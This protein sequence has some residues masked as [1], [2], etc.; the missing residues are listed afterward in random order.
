MALDYLSKK[1]NIN[2]N[3][4]FSVDKNITSYDI[5]KTVKDE[6]SSQSWDLS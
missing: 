6:N 4:S 3:A 2:S 1:Y 5:G